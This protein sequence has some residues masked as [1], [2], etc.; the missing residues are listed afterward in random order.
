MPAE[1]RIVVGV[2]G[3]LGSIAALHHAAAEARRTDVELLAVL[4]WT[5]P[6]DELGYRRTP[7]PPALTAG[8]DAAVARLRQALDEAFAGHHAGVRLR[9]QAVRGDTGRTLVGCA[10]RPD[11]LLVLG[12]GHERGRLSRLLRPSVAAY[13][14]RHATCP[15]LTVPRPA[16]QRDLE[17][18][19]RGHGLR[20]SVTGS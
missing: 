5:P 15:V 20:Q 2:S 10:D 18:L 19:E 8:R 6:G 4:C 1:S 9:C 16:L 14:V 12:A 11:D 13:C 3:S 17:E 7:Y